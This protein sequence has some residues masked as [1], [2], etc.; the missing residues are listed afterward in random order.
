MIGVI[1]GYLKGKIAFSQ[2]N[3]L[4]RRLITIQKAVR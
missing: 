4:I 2:H 1:Q 3:K